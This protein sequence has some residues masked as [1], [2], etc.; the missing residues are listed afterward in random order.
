MVHMCNFCSQSADRIS[1]ADKK[2]R[3]QNNTLHT[4]VDFSSPLTVTVTVTISASSAWNFSWLREVAAESPR[5]SQTFT[6]TESPVA[7]VL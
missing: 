5:L 4:S 3:D 2:T 7:G 1:T 6:T